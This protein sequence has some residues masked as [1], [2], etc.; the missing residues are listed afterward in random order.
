M[1]FYSPSWLAASFV[2]LLSVLVLVTTYTYLPKVGPIL[3]ERHVLI[4]PISPNSIAASY[5]CGLK[6]SGRY[7]FDRDRGLMMTTL[8]SRSIFL[9]QLIV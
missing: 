3:G 5:L 8:E 2:I 9:L 4:I 6:E 7:V 1:V